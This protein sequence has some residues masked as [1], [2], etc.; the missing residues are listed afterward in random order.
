MIV[1]LQHGCC[2]LFGGTFDPAYVMAVFALPVDITPTKNRRNAALLQKHMEDSLGVSSSRGHLR[3]VAVPEENSAR[4]GKTVAGEIAETAGKEG[5]QNVA[6]RERT[7][8]ILTVK[9]RL[10]F[11][12]SPSLTWYSLSPCL[13]Q[14]H[15]TLN[16]SPQNQAETAHLSGPR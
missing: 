4:N 5:A 11:P 3:F 2:M 1:T 13:D 6:P 16:L 8:S 7:A 9:A 14:C 15:A 10:P 12:T